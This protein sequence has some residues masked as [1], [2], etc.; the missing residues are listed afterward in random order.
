MPDS[1]CAPSSG[2]SRT[3]GTPPIDDA[4]ALLP[5][6]AEITLL[7]V[8]STESETLARAARRGLLGRPHAHRHPQPRSRY[9]RSSNAPPTSYSPQ[10]V[11]GSAA[12]HTPGAPRTGRT[13][14]HGRREGHGHPRPPRDGDR[15]RVGPRSVG[16]TTRLVIDHAP[17]RVLLI[18][19]DT[20]PKLA[21]LPPPRHL[22]AASASPPAAQLTPLPSSCVG[23]AGAPMGSTTVA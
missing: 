2:S 7:H 9:A 18:W 23:R 20:A 12:S 6:D 8:A 19:P 17:S 5:G 16:P 14:G 15:K 1:M 13:R 4:N 22:R 10:P 11:R 21:T 3:A